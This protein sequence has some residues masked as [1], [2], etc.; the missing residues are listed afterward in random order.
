MII[1]SKIVPR[2][3]RKRLR[4]M[5]YGKASAF[6][7]RPDLIRNVTDEAVVLTS[8]PELESFASSLI[9]LPVTCCSAPVVSAKNFL[10]ARSPAGAFSLVSCQD[11]MPDRGSFSIKKSFFP[12]Q[13]PKS[14][15]RR[16]S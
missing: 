2:Q 1:V 13:N 15:V 12:H 16:F 7:Q 8:E 5:N 9:R 10:Q 3:S 4:G 11:L 6:C 14:A